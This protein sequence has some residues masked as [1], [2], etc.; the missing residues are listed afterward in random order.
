MKVELENATLYLGD[1]MDILP[2]LDKVDAVITD[3]PYGIGYDPSVHKRY[4]GS[5]NEYT[6]IYGDSTEMDFS[7]IFALPCQ[8]Y[9]G[10]RK[11]FTANFLTVA[12]GSAGISV[13]L[14]PIPTLC[15]AVILNLLGTIGILGSTSTSTSSTVGQ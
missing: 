11:T 4:D 3:P 9:Y 12:A 5:E 8:K 7:A 2:T 10:A 15:Q 6:S 1:C 14:P 13:A